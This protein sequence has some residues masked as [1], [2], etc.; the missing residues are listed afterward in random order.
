MSTGTK[1]IGYNSSCFSGISNKVI[2][3]NFFTDSVYPKC[4]VRQGYS[5]CQRHI[6]YINIHMTTPYFLV[7]TMTSKS[8]RLSTKI[9]EEA[10]RA[11]VNI[12]IPGKHF[13]GSWRDMTDSP[14]G[15]SWSTDRWSH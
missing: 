13:L 2:I 1:F 7:T 15:I 14:R 3:N 5:R 11:K 6:K 12:E 9:N 8:C 10:S 4:G